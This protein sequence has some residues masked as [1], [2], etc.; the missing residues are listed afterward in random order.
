MGVVTS[1]VA[2]WMMKRDLRTDRWRDGLIEDTSRDPNHFSSVDAS[3]GGTLSQRS[4]HILAFIIPLLFASNVAAMFALDLQ[5]GD[6]TALIGGTSILIM[7]IVT[8]M[9]YRG[10][11]LE[12]TTGY[13]N[14][15]FLFGFRVFEPVIPIAAFFYL[16]DSGFFAMFGEKL[17]E[18]SR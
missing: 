7:L 9:T 8:M 2:F 12:K 13:L 4:K 5:G 3:D 11:G 17:P 1:V 18:A 16:G 14:D 6:A 15:G 10:K